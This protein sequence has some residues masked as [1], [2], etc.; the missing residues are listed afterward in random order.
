MGSGLA[1]VAE[2]AAIA[3]LI[4]SIGRANRSHAPGKADFWLVGFALT[5]CIMIG[6]MAAEPTFGGWLIG[7]LALAVGGSLGGWLA[8]ATPS[9]KIAQLLA[10]LLA[11]HGL[12]AVLLS[13][14]V[15][16]TGPLFWDD[17]M[18]ATE[19][20]RSLGTAVA[21]LFGAA[22]FGGG[23]SLVFRR[24][25]FGLSRRLHSL[26]PFRL[27]LV[28]LAAIALV[29]FAVWLVPG[30]FLLTAML[31]TATG[32]VV[33]LS[34]DDR[35]LPLAA[36]VLTAFGGLATAAIGFAFASIA[37]IVAGG[38]AGAIMIARYR[39]MCREHSLGPFCLIVE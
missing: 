13:F 32:I 30:F 19:F 27:V 18:I 29:L 33:V 21:T 26:E 12:V 2:L 7:F 23:M 3:F 9:K 24:L 22:A 6:L 31:S 10:G 5:L 20:E 28:G 37:L 35:K 15:V 17:R 4:F 34:A 36:V 8:L 25:R 11:L 14:S 39:T 38:L 1:A 16:N